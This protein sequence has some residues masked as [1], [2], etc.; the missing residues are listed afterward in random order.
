[1][2]GCLSH[3]ASAAWNR[4]VLEGGGQGGA[5]GHA[6]SV[7]SNR[8]VPEGGGQEGLPEPRRQRRLE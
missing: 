3:S 8:K 7:A 1:M 6:A 2:R 5:W 4:R